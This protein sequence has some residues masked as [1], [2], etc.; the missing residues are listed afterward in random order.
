MRDYAILVRDRHPDRAPDI[1]VIPYGFSWGAVL[2]QALWALYRGVWL[3]AVVLLVAGLT[4]PVATGLLRLDPLVRAAVE[5]GGAIVL[6]LAA[7][8]LARFELVRRGFALNGIVSARS[9][10]EAEVRGIHALVNEAGE[11][12]REVGGVTELSHSQGLQPLAN[13]SI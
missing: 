11:Q 1:A 13:R 5:L 3:T 7:F 10:A 9:L 8:D 2:F 6:A 12:S 4:I